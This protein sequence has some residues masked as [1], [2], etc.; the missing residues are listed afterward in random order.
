MAVIDIDNFKSINDNFG[1]LAGD[2]VLHAIAQTLQKSIRKT[3][4]IARFGGEEFALLLPEINQQQAQFVLNKLRDRIKAIT[5]RFKEENLIITISVGF[6]T[7]VSSDDQD[8]AFERAD[9]ALYQAKAE[10]KDRVIFIEKT[11]T[12][13]K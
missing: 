4:Y 8:E 2:K 12:D 1:H 13:D 10:G 5:F 3:D 11:A 7:L 9:T 6:T